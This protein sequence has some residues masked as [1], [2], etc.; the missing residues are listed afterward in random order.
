MK[1]NRFLTRALSTL[2]V[3]LH[4]AAVNPVYAENIKLMDELKNKKKPK[5]KNGLVFE[6]LI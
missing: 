6:I 4:L 5:F 3:P 1:N 2:L